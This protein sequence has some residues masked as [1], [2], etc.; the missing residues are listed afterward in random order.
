M[1]AADAAGLSG[2][3]RLR[4]AVLFGLSWVALAAARGL[5]LASDCLTAQARLRLAPEASA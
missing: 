5:L 2:A 1:S 3:D 4:L